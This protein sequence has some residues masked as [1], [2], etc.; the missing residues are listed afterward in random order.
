MKTSCRI[1]RVYRWVV[2]MAAHLDVPSDKLLHF[3]C[4]AVIMIILMPVLG[5][6]LATIATIGICIGKEI[7]DCHKKHPSG[8]S[9]GDLLADLL[10]I[11]II[12]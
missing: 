3:V 7:Y 12:L 8:W 2:T 1:T 5:K 9:W 11:L 6:C 10:G 4:S